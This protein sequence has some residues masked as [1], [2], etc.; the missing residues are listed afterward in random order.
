MAE[1]RE[2]FV[3]VTE[4]GQL[5][6]SDDY[7]EFFTSEESAVGRA[8]EILSNITDDEGFKV[9]KTK[10]IIEPVDNERVFRNETR[11]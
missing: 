6:H 7:T 11:V 10:L 3:I 8:E 2:G 4:D 5:S 1:I 9:A